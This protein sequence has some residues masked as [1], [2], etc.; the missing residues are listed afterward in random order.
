MTV[1]PIVYRRLVEAA[2]GRETITVAELARLT[3]LSAT[4]PTGRTILDLIFDNIAAAEVDER[5]PLLPVVVTEAD[6]GPLGAGLARYARRT[7][8]QADAAFLAAELARVHDYWVS[9]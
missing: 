9:H 3:E 1:N 5:R 4:D 7:G 8:T 2:K 6:G